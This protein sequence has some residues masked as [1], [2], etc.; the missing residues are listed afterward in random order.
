MKIKVFQYNQNG[1]IEFTPAELEKLLN[2]VYADGQRNCTCNKTFT[3][4][5][6]S[7][8]DVLYTNQTNATTTTDVTNTT[9]PIDDFKAESVEACNADRKPFIATMKLNESD[10]N[11][12]V[13]ALHNMINSNNAIRSK[14]LNDVFSNLAKELNF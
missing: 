5:S 8:G 2:E 4:T 14:E 10:V 13:N 1:K 9:K 12:A 7:L 6:P 3:W 11:K